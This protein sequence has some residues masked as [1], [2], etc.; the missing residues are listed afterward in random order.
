[1]TMGNVEFTKSI[2]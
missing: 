1:M 2:L